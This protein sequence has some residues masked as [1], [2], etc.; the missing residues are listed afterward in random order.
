MRFGR[1]Q[2]LPRS[3]KDEALAGLEGAA[4]PGQVAA[5]EQ[6]GNV[7]RSRPGA[8]LAKNDS[9]HNLG[10][11]RQFGTGLS[12]ESN[13]RTFFGEKGRFQQPAM[14]VRPVPDVKSPMQTNPNAMMG[15]THPGW[16]EG[17]RQRT[18]FQDPVMNRLA[19]VPA[20]AGFGA[21][22]PDNP[23][24]LSQRDPA[25]ATAPLPPPAAAPDLST[26]EGL[27][28]HANDTSLQYF[29]RTGSQ[30]AAPQPGQ[31]QSGTALASK[32]GTAS[33]WNASDPLGDP[34]S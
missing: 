13:W 6:A 34:F 10:V 19:N 3:V 20:A 8:P 7:F 29:N 16:M 4:T 25:A 18:T 12:K 2:S 5:Y 31:V 17:A 30:I 24:I 21:S 23:T 26:P 32:Y 27:L 11:A 14:P 15:D 28:A 22:S 33:V 1:R 9:M